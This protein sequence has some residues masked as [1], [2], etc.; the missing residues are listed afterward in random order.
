MWSDRGAAAKLTAVLS[1]SV[2]SPWMMKGEKL[3]GSVT[4]NP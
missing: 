4:C 3:Y 1:P 2:L